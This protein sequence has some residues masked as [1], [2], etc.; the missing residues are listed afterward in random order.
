MV[1]LSD[2]TGLLK[3]TDIVKSEYDSVWKTL[4]SDYLQLGYR[5]SYHW[6]RLDLTTKEVFNNRLFWYFEDAITQD[7]Q[8]H[9]LKNNQIIESDTFGVDYSFDKR[10]IKH[11]YSILAFNIQP[12]DTLT[13]LLR[14]HND[15]NENASAVT[16]TTT[17][18]HN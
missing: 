17:W 14:L 13:L 10:N 6:I 1:Y 2:S 9:L 8:F 18:A 16:Y 7:V 5:V 15:L 3:P 12:N 4:P 11:R